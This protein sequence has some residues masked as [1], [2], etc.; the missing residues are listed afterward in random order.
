[1]NAA[2]KWYVKGGAYRLNRNPQA[3]D[4]KERKLAKNF[5]SQFDKLSPLSQPMQLYRGVGH[6]SYTSQIGQYWSTSENE[7]IAKSFTAEELYTDT[8]TRRTRCRAVGEVL[9]IDVQP[10]VRVMPIG[11]VQR[12]WVIEK[13]V[14]VTERRRSNDGITWIWLTVTAK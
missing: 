2:Q 3:L 9:I 1:M 14:N 13:N 6:G 4:N 8:L 10:G 5:T 7:D 12:E 11:G